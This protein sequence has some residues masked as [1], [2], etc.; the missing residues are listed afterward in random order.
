MVRKLKTRYCL[1]C[2]R[3]S[4]REHPYLCARCV[5]INDFWGSAFVGATKYGVLNAEEYQAKRQKAGE[6]SPIELNLFYKIM[7]RE[8]RQKD[9]KG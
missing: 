8:R 2:G 5:S 7:D 3:T 6:H 9:V 1:R 4:K